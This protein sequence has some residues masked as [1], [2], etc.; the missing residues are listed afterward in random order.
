MGL[1]DCYVIAREH[2]VI[3]V[4]FRRRPEPPAPRFPGAGALRT[5][6]ACH[7]SPDAELS[8]RLLSC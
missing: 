8:V 1:T 7:D 5:G 4:D 6:D 2:N 3:R